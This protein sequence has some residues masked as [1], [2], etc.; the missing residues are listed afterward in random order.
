[1]ISKTP[2]LPGDFHPGHSDSN[3]ITKKT[4]INIQSG[5]M[6]YW[7]IPALILIALMKPSGFESIP[8][9]MPVDVMFTGFQICSIIYALWLYLRQPISR[10][11]VYILILYILYALPVILQGNPVNLLSSDSL[12]LFK[13]IVIV[14]IIE[15]YISQGYSRVLIRGFIIGSLFLLVANLLITFAL[16]PGGLYSDF[17]DG[18]YGECFL[19]NKNAVR[20]PLL[21]GFG[22]SLTLDAL[23]RK[24]TSRCTIALI[25]IGLINLALVWSAT[26]LVVFAVA[27]AL[28]LLSLIGMKIPSAKVLGLAVAISWFV[29]VV[30]R[31]TDL[32]QHFVVDILQKDMTF[33]GRTVMWDC[34]FDLISQS[35][36]LGQ[37]FGSYLTY[38][39]ANNP[40]LQVPHCHNAFVDAMY[41][42]GGFSFVIL[43]ATIVL[44]CDRLQSVD[45]LQIKGGLTITI[46]AF[47]FMGIFGELLNP[48]FMAV[49][50]I[51]ACS[52][53]LEECVL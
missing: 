10:M 3:N 17:S 28:Y 21:I 20:N 39:N 13:I 29:V 25:I 27:C 2:S 24:R 31:K 46:T 5:W 12:N 49:L 40:F 41:K 1:M 19:G 51:T 26:S 22:C 23:N 43:V 38:W 44:A 7:I 36:V 30:L 14:M 8:W 4:G 9:M 6:R 18:V 45:N 52:K 47:L 53:K 35:P 33:S 37:G 34:A 15:S 16:N 50:A 32:F 11:I 48:C 42:G